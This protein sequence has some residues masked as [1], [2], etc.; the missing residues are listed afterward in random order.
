MTQTLRS[1]RIRED[2]VVIDGVTYSTTPKA[3]QIFGEIGFIHSINIAGR[4]FFPQDGRFISE[5]DDA[6]LDE[7]ELPILKPKGKKK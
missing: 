6:P 5:I 7:N 1:F 3:V 4:Q 2:V